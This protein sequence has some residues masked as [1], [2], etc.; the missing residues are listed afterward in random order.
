MRQSPLTGVCWDRTARMTQR[1][2]SC[3]YQADVKASQL[4]FPC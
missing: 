3:G 2:P 1:F 4:G